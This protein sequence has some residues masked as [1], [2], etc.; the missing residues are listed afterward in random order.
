MQIFVHVHL[1]SFTGL[2][3]SYCDRGAE[4]G[5]EEDG[6]GEAGGTRKVLDTVGEGWLEISFQTMLSA[7]NIPYL[8]KL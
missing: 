8:C 5:R 4:D 2:T 3:V 6:G 7:A 1:D